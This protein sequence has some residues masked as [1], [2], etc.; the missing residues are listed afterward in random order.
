MK[1]SYALHKTQS[2][3]GSTLW[4]FPRGWL[5]PLALVYVGIIETHTLLFPS[6]LSALCM[7]EIVGRR[8]K[9]RIA[10]F[11]Q[12]TKN[13][14]EAEHGGHNKGCEMIARAFWVVIVIRGSSL[15]GWDKSSIVYLAAGHGA[16]V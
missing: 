9:K 5:D 7:P 8:K 10:T 12:S 2:T 13:M 4:H 11:C 1:Q 14:A 6:Q 15:K 3:A 16:P